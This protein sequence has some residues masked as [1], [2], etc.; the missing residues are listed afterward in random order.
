[1]AF[2][3]CISHLFKMNHLKKCNNTE[4]K[5]VTIITSISVLLSYSGNCR[6]L[7]NFLINIFNN[8][9]TQWGPTVRHRELHPVSRDRTRWKRVW[10]RGCLRM[11]V[12]VT[13]LHGSTWRN[14]AS[15]LYFKNTVNSLTQ[16][17][18]SE[19]TTVTV[20]HRGLFP[21]KQAAGHLGEN[22]SQNQLQHLLW[23]VTS[24][25]DDKNPL[26][27][28]SPLTQFPQFVGKAT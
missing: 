20:T 10:G 14:P 15:Q 9:D 3:Q 2:F 6:A 28:F 1:M 19:T 7:M 22:R 13:L 17:T 8:R 26:D 18:Q 27:T 5:K 21:L 23:T 12:W 25:E 11:G 4:T 16:V 24:G